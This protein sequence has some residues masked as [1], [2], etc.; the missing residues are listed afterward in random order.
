MYPSI[1]MS[2]NISPETKL[3][4]LVGWNAQEFIKGTIKTYTELM[5]L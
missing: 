5:A 3:G 2:L 4:K 1:I